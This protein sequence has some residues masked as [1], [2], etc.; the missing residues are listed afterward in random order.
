MHANN[1][2]APTRT[3]IFFF[4]AAVVFLFFYFFKVF[5]LGLSDPFFSVKKGKKEAEPGVFVV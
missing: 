4:P 2:R 5:T 1:T 3:E